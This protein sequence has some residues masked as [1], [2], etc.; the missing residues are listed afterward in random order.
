MDK[1]AHLFFMQASAGDLRNFF[2][3]VGGVVDVRIL[4][5]KFTKKSRVSSIALYSPWLV[6]LAKG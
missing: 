5:D 1:I 3:D 4:K 6:K 2:S